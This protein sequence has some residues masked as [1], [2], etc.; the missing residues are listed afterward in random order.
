MVRGTMFPVERFGDEHLPE[1]GVDVEN[2]VGRLI[3]PHPGD[4]VSDRDVLV[5]VRAD[6]QDR[7]DPLAG[8]GRRFSNTAAVEEN[9]PSVW[10]GSKPWEEKLNP[11]FQFGR[12]EINTRRSRH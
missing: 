2:L 11:V 3:C 10:E 9:F 12:D 4:A 1:D 6:L 5:L 7:R 8:T